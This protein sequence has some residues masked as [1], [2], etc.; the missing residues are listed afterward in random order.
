[1]AVEPRRQAKGTLHFA[2]QDDGLECVEQ[3]GKYG[4]DSEDGR[5]NVHA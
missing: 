3:D 1:M 4:E 5:E 2:R